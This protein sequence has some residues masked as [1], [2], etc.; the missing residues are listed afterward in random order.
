MDE[1]KHESYREIHGSYA[2]I[3]KTVDVILKAEDKIRCFFDGTEELVFVACGSSYWMSLSAS[4]MVECRTG[5]RSSAIRAGDVV[6]HQNDYIYTYETPVFIVPSRSGKTKEVLEAIKILK[7]RYPFAKVFSVT[8]YEPNDVLEVSD[9]NISIPFANEVSV[10]QT[11]SFNCLWTAFIMIVSII[12]DDN[13]LLNSLRKYL[14]AAPALYAVGEKTVKKII[15]DQDA[16]LVVSLGSGVQYGI[17]IEGA[18]I[19]I[20]MAEMASNYYQ[21]M[22]FRHGPVVTAKK[23]VLVCICSGGPGT[24]EYEKKMAEETRARGARVV[25]VGN[26]LGKGWY[27][28]GISIGEDYPPEVMSLYYIFVM[29][30][31][32]YYLALDKGGD[33]DNP[34]QLVRYITF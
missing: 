1:S 11:R 24:L 26:N 6:M 30:S 23:D 21:L 17:V 16:R 33:P 3:G 31:L 15:A 28:Y 34:G 4:K 20:E 29:Q 32:A 27:D 18:Y 8:E 14:A 13:G 7:N 25:V 12:A 5:K 9:L 2:E 22:E 10:C 19:I